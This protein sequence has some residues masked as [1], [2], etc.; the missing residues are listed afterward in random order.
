[1]HSNKILKITLIF[2]IIIIVT[3]LPKQKQVKLNQKINSNQYM[4]LVENITS[5]KYVLK[6]NYVIDI[7]P[8]TSKDTFLSEFTPIGGELTLNC[9][10]TKYIGS[11]CEISLINEEE[12]PLIY[13]TIVQ[14]DVNGDG[15]STITD[16]VQTALSLD[17]NQTFS[18]ESYKLA[19]DVD[20]NN[21]LNKEDVLTLAHY[22]VLKKELP[23]PS[24]INKKP[25]IEIE[26]KRITLEKNKSYQIK[27]KYNQNNINIVEWKSS[28]EEI[29]VVDSLGKITGV[30]GGNTT[31]SATTSTGEIISVKI[32]VIVMPTGVILDKNSLEMKRGE[33][34]NLIASVSPSDAYD[35]TVTYKSENTNIVTVDNNGAVKAINGGNTTISV[36][37]INGITTT[38]PVSVTVPVTNISLNKTKIEMD[39][40]KTTSLTATIAPSDATNKDV[41]WKSS[42]TKVATV[43]ANGVITAIGNGTVIITAVSKENSNISTSCTIEVSTVYNS[44]TSLGIISLGSPTITVSP[45]TKAFIAQGFCVT[46]DYYIT[47]LKDRNDTYTLI[48]VYDKKTKKV[49]N[50]FSGAFG[51]AN[52]M[53]V[54]NKYLYIVYNGAD[55]ED[56]LVGT[57]AAI[58]YKIPIED[59]LKEKPNIIKGGFYNASNDSY[60]KISGIYYDDYNDLYYLQKGSNVRVYNAKTQKVLKTIK[61][62]DNDTPQD[63]GG[64]NGKAIVIRYNSGGDATGKDIDNARNAIDIYRASDGAYLGSYAI[65][66]SIEIESIDYTGNG[67]EFALYF[68]KSLSGG[69]IY[70]VNFAI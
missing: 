28:N 51:H 48:R 21:L 29:A 26:A 23:T 19:G 3:S 37:T 36:T 1:M 6:D 46:D 53:T 70:T 55:V 42:N 24:S 10:T 17:D 66:S 59:L 11:G 7:L 43:D 20:A 58:Y 35:K 45:T 61:K 38:I 34:N 62:V 25:L 68:Y 30:G 69:V 27:V 2:L 65:A 47:T 64:Y 60:I 50:E 49:V 31:I 12:A 41:I 9:N 8:K 40:G 4:E 63:I 57:E 52:G 5:E 16:I 33:S 13:E 14:G 39:K 32:K 54:D 15:E 56:D 18:K 44:L 22:N 67:Q